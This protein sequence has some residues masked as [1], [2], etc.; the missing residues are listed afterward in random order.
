VLSGRQKT[1]AGE[2][3]ALTAFS[4]LVL[5]LAAASGADPALAGW[6]A[7]VWWVSFSLGTL[8]VHAIKA[9]HK[10]TQ[11]SRW[12][13]W[14]SPVASAAVVAGCLI[15][16]FTQ[17]QAFGVPAL[18]LLPPAAGVLILGLI[19]VH[20][21]HLKRVGWTLVGANTLALVLL[22]WRPLG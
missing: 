1:L 2:L 20:P 19:R 22:L 11:R 4:T 6:A 8:E 14:G 5:P 13:R 17:G 7:S 18:A 21:R 10:N 3:L 15:G 9:R 16:V 12:T